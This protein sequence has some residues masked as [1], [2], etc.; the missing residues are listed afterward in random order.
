MNA[1]TVILAGLALV[2]FA[3][4]MYLVVVSLGALLRG[5]AKH[6]TV[7]LLVAVALVCA[8]YA[9]LALAAYAG[10]FRPG[11]PVLKIVDD[12]AQ[13]HV[14]VDALKDFGAFRLARANSAIV[15]K[16]VSVRM[17][18]KTVSAAMVSAGSTGTPTQVTV[19][20]GSSVDTDSNRAESTL[21]VTL[22]ARLGPDNAGIKS[23]QVVDVI[24]GL[25]VAA[26]NQAPDKND[27]ALPLVWSVNQTEGGQLVL[28][29][30]DPFFQRQ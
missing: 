5:E 16:R 30:S 4:T 27:W 26:N 13:G 14:D 11:A 6:S 18:V 29:V 25:A 22:V 19:L 1:W 28:L 20:V 15:D 3:A 9:S 21:P 24:G 23:G 17:L 12:A 2:L 8:G 10:E 7:R